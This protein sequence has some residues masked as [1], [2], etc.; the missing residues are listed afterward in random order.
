M[1]DLTFPKRKTKTYSC[2]RKR[3]QERNTDTPLLMGSRTSCQKSVCDCFKRITLSLFSNTA[4]WRQR[5]TEGTAPCVL[6][7]DSRWMV[8]IVMPNALTAHKL[9]VQTEW[10]QYAY[11]L[12][13]LIIDYVVSYDRSI[14]ASKA[15][16]P[17]S[18][19]YCFQ[20]LLFSLKS[21]SSCLRLL[22]CFQ[23]PIFGMVVY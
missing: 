13:S 1:S 7:N 12:G 21:F 8:V 9:D 20:Y 11:N 15:S 18:E 19:I 4:Q 17:Q 22:S 16:S 23:F 10:E 3:R 6:N 2:F 5:G 14:D